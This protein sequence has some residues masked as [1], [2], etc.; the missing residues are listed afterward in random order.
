MT[1]RLWRVCALLFASG[2]CALVYQVAWFRALRLIFGA[3]TA[4]SAAVLAVFMG[5]LGVGGAILGKR[6]DR[7]ENPLSTYANLEILV[8]LT[9]AISPALVWAAQAAY[10]GIGGA[11][12]VGGAGA[13]VLRLVLSVLVLGPSTFLMGGTLPNAARAVERASDLGRQR[14]AALYGVN[15]M[16]AV[17]GAVAANFLLLEVFGTRMTLW[18]ACCVNAL[19]GVAARMLA[20]S[21]TEV[22]AEPADAAEPP[23]AP[24]PVTWF[25]PLAAA[26]AGGAFMLMELVWYRML[27]PLLGGSSYTFGIILAIAL[28]G[29]G[30]G[31]S[32]YARRR[33]ASTLSLFALTCTLEAVTIGI[34]Y[35]LGDRI[36]LLALLSRPL[37]KPGFAWSAL[38]WTLIASVAVL[39]PAIVSGFQFPAIIGLYGRGKER[40][41]R[42]VGNAYLA[43]TLGAIAGSLAGGF[44]LLPLLTAPRAWLLVIGILVATALLAL[45]LDVRGQRIDV[46]RHGVIAFTAALAV[47]VF[48]ATGPTAVWRHS[49]I[50]AGRADA[51]ANDF[52]RVER[53]KFVRHQRN[54]IAWEEEG[55]ESSV[56][57]SYTTG[58]GFIVNGK[59]DGHTIV[60]A[61][62]QVMSGLVA[63]F[64]HPQ[65]KSALVI[66]LGTGSSAGW[67]GVVPTIERVDVVEL[68]PSI[69]RVAKDCAPVNQNVIANPK[70]HITLGDAREVLRT[71]RQTYDIIFSEPSNPYRAGISS[72]YT[73]EYYR[74]AR[75]RMN[76]GGYFVQWLQAYEV[77][78]W[79]VATVVTTIHEVFPHVAI[80]KTTAGDLLAIASAEPP[81]PLDVAQARARLAA[82]PYQTAVRA[83]WQ[84]ASLEGFLSHHIG[85]ER[86]VE[87]LIQENRGSVNTDDE[88]LL[89]FALARSVGLHDRH[90]DEE[91]ERLG[92]RLGLDQV[93]V[94]GAIDGD[95]VFD[96]RMLRKMRENE[97]DPVATHAPESTKQLA[98]VIR[99]ITSGDSRGGLDAWRKLGRPIRA[100]AEHGILAHAAASTPD[101]DA[102]RILESLPNEGERAI[103]RAVQANHERKLEQAVAHL[104][105]A[106]AGLRTDPWVPASTVATGLE[107]AHTIG[108][109]EPALARRLAEALG[110]KFAVELFRSLRIETRIK[111]ARSAHDP[112][113]CV[114]AL[115]EMNPLSWEPELL[116]TRAVCFKEAND[117]RLG[118]A[119]ED[120]GRSL[121]WTSQIGDGI[122]TPK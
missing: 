55:L 72:L 9:A 26:V 75:E 25:P 14:V 87:R 19:V 122:P 49:G 30:L 45:A 94:N 63:S 79:A 66:G 12:T 22:E 69:L 10:I 84:T 32:L 116:K 57:L 86:L 104:E 110:P 82:E 43:N 56:A 35:A 1:F 54:G 36:A 24:M 111:L 17:L 119:E 20:R 2:A 78:D 18:L 96:E 77:D 61:P 67:L 107:L 31:S 97:P 81:G 16:G 89:E 76:R 109:R 99:H 105:H 52:G 68:E 28:V 113:L 4:A 40:V 46:R 80:W 114:T 85:S 34:P 13:T 60:D 3:S 39:L 103:L 98:Q 51:T 42:D 117:P 5:G 88:N 83:A 23:A 48:F 70:V 74:A 93:E 27:A 47:A 102:D 6:A 41:G 91:I 44:G 112:R 100:Y 120:L 50:G 95:L 115:D 7:A 21:T 108:T 29:I 118:E 37:T 90:V 71:T 38:V 8:A 73:L 11:S 62:T 92:D 15:T 106:F 65:P 121:T 33:V 101:P 64:L 53:E 58:Y 59:A